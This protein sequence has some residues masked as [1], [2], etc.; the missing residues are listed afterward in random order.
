MESPAELWR[1]TG[2]DWAL[3]I[4]VRVHEEMAFVS[5]PNI[6]LLKKQRAILDGFMSQLA[7]GGTEEE[8]IIPLLLLQENAKRSELSNPEDIVEW[9]RTPSTEANLPHHEGVDEFIAHW[10]VDS[11]LEISKAAAATIYVSLCAQMVHWLVNRRRGVN[12]IFGRIEP[13]QYRK[14]WKEILLGRAVKNVEASTLKWPNCLY[15]TAHNPTPP[16]MCSSELVAF[17]DGI[18]EW[19][20]EFRASTWFTKQSNELENNRRQRLG[21]NYLA[22]VCRTVMGHYERARETYRKYLHEQS[23]KITSLPEFNQGDGGFFTTVKTHAKGK[24]RNAVRAYVLPPYII[25]PP[26]APSEPEGPESAN[27]ALPEVPSV[28]CGDSAV[29]ETG[30]DLE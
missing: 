22:S 24:A 5:V 8:R 13:F 2:S 26:V 23:V 3:P 1:I 28:P 30:A 12:L 21:P 9:K 7:T 17:K 19:T 4:L 10:L 25:D 11:G 20:L 29:R 16:E 18:C 15:V 14:N 27:G 6:P